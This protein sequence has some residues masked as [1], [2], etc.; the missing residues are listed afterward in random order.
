M[1][2]K[3]KLSKKRKAIYLIV[4]LVLIMGGTA[5]YMIVFV[6]DIPKTQPNVNHKVLNSLKISKD[7]LHDYLNNDLGIIETG[8]F[9]VRENR[10]DVNSN[11]IEL[12]FERFKT[13]SK[14]PLAPIFFLA[15][16]PGSSSTR[17]G[18]TEYFFLFKELSKYADVVL[19]DQRGT[20]K[21]IPNLECRNSLDLPIDITENVQE[22][23]MKD[24]LDKCK[25]C[26]D[27]FIAM[28]ITLGAYNSYQSVM[29]LEDIRK[30]LKYDKITLYGYSYGTELA[31]I[32]MKYFEKHVGNAI[33]AGALA[34]DHGLKLPQDVQK[35]Y[36]KMDSLIRLDKKL[37]EYIPSFLDLIKRVHEQVKNNPVEVKIPIKDAFGNNPSGSEN[38]LAEVISIFRPTIDMTLTETHLQM[39]V[40]DKVGTDNAIERLPSLYYM[41]SQGNYREVGNTLR[42]FKRR[43]LPNA[44]F[45]T[46]NGA[47]RYTE[48]L[49]ERSI[50]QEDS[51][52]FSHFGISYGRYPE[53]FDA[54]GI[55]KT[56]G[57]NNPVYGSTKTLFITGDLDGRTPKRLT[58]TIASRFPNSKIITM[59]NTGH[60]RLLNNAVMNAVIQFIKDSLSSNI[61]IDN[62]IRFRPPV[63]FQYS[64]VDTIYQKIHDG[65]IQEGMHFYEKLHTEYGQI[66]DYIFDFSEEVFVELY[67]RF[68]EVKKYDKAIEVLSFG[69]RLFPNNHH[70]YASLGEVYSLTGRKEEAIEHL[71]KALDFNFFDGRSQSLLLKLRSEK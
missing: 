25:E 22:E 21:S 23:V 19:L 10:E 61:I 34:P 71:Q 40:S 55:S 67:D 41:M 46:V 33:L 9:V 7:T 59:Q 8:K 11:L 57:M 68:I 53:V 36:V 32:Y 28:G 62:P 52:L 16:G 29:D 13:T 50:A 66:N 1:T 54:F 35:Q 43:R 60:N 18:K 4:T 63:P 58:D 37:S 49:W 26:A 51:T 12:Y 42:N 15:G 69:I 38:T 44:L 5:M 70:I 20:G 31:Q 27:E 48:K 3:K 56:E 30:V 45:F 24:L 6:S 65:G 17:I 47:S 64:M 39:M 14:E 2:A